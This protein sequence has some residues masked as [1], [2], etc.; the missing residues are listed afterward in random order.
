[1]NRTHLASRCVVFSLVITLAG[2]ATWT[3][4]QKKWAG[5]AAGVLVVGAIAAH[6]ADHGGDNTAA[7]GGELVKPGVPCH[8]Q[9]DGSCR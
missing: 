4:T 3:P 1:M 9:P 2:C 6:K 7:N 8:M 5:V